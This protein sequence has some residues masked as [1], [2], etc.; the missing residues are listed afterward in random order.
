[1]STDILYKES[2]YWISQFQTFRNEIQII[3]KSLSDSD[4][5]ESDHLT[6]DGLLESIIVFIEHL[7]DTDEILFASINNGTYLLTRP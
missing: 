6:T 5:M 4:L 3:K 1:M 2:M 7:D